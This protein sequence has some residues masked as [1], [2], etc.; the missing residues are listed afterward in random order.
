MNIYNIE[1][2]DKTQYELLR[3]AIMHN[4]KSLPLSGWTFNH[5]GESLHND[6][7][8]WVVYESDFWIGA[9]TAI[10]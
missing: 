8:S 10:E 9:T 3:D 7:E 1:I 2:Q 6:G 5:D 4:P